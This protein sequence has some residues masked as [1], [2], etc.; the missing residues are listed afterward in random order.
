MMTITPDIKQMGIKAKQASRKLAAASTES[1]NDCLRLIAENLRLRK[2]EILTANQI[3]INAARS[4]KQK[5]HIIER[6]VLNETRIND[7]IN[8]CRDIAVLED[9]IGKILESRSLANGISLERI[10]VPLGVLGVIY[11]SRPNVTIDI[12]AL[13]LKSGNSVILRGGK[14]AFQT[15][16]IL[17][18]IVISTLE[19]QSLP[20]DSV[21]FVSSTKRSLVKKM[22]GLEDYIDLIIPRGSAELVK[23]VGENALMPA[24]TGGV[25]VCHTYVDE[26]AN[27]EK[28]IDII[29][30]AKVQRPTVCNALDTVL[31]HE[32]IADRLLPILAKQF[33]INKVEMRGDSQTLKIIGRENKISNVCIP[34]TEKDFGTEFLDL[35]ASVKVVDSLNEAIDHIA[36]YGSRHSEAI[37]AD[38]KKVQ[39]RFLLEVDA[40]AV[41]SNTSTRFNDGGEFG[42]G[43]EIAVSTNKL[44]AR[45]PMGLNEIT[46]YKWI[47]RGD[48]Q[49]RT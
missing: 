17:A 32:N 44:H 36:K 6:M 39:E 38:N 18:D 46:T 16:S 5:E 12:T 11:E 48:G 25:G 2:G 21:Q 33:N 3:D 49:I 1:K 10:R 27:L 28:A 8:A 22:L 29:I 35:I 26:S 43:A 31:V 45:G 30:N 34:A 9:P 47:A 15:N 19:S 42:L 13:C 7:M 14:E 37:I 23:F 20:V 4:A 40:G 41:F 24:V